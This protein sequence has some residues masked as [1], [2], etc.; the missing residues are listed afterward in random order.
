MKGNFILIPLALAAVTSV[1]KAADRNYFQV[2][3]FAKATHKS[4]IHD[5]YQRA[6]D[7][8]RM[9]SVAYRNDARGVE[10]STFRNSM[11]SRS[12]ALSYARYWQPLKYVETSVHVGVV[13]GYPNSAILFAPGI[14]YRRYDWAIPK[15]TWYGNALVFSMSIK[16]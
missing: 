5:T 11:Y 16:F 7:D 10:L 15:L 4:I 9:L 8:L 2:T 12:A 14:A 1:A 6:N 3:Y 13:S